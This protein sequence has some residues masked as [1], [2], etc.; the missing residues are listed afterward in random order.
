MPAHSRWMIRCS[1]MYLVLGFLLGAL[2]LINKVYP[3]HGAI[4]MLMPVHIEMLIFGWIIQFTLGTA[5]WMLPRFL[6]G[7]P[8]GSTYGA[9]AMVLMLN[10]GIILVVL[11]RFGI[12][13][14]PLDIS[15][16]ILETVSVVLFIVLHWNRVVSYRNKN[17]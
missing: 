5:Y 6:E 7:E 17:S 10:T 14:L 8:R 1:F 9:T 13:D 15:G 4:R 11:D 2:M 12:S 16:R 3:L